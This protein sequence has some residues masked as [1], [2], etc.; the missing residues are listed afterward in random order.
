MTLNVYLQLSLAIRFKESPRGKFEIPLGTFLDTFFVTKKYRMFY[1]KM[2]IYQRENSGYFTEI[3][4][5]TPKGIF[6]KLR[7]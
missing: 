5:K 6:K 3:L 1:E 7:I 4:L 2:F